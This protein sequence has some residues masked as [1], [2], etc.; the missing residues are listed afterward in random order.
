M[1]DSCMI[2]TEA[3]KQFH[4]LLSPHFLSLLSCFDNTLS[5]H[6]LRDFTE[7]LNQLSNSLQYF[8]YIKYLY[9]NYLTTE[10][11]LSGIRVISFS[12]AI[13]FEDSALFR[14]RKKAQS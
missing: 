4:S 1:L 9:Y 11:K 12:A 7:I 2:N 8:R 3:K 6:D 10:I 13:A 14:F 5:V